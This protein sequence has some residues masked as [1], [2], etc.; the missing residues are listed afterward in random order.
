MSSAQ[1]KQAAAKPVWEGGARV[2]FHYTQPDDAERILAEQIFR[3]AAEPGRAGHGLYVTTVQ[4]RSMPD[5]KLLDLLFAR[6]RPELFV[7]GVV[8]LRD[9]AFSWE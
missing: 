5:E 7:E 2:K 6:G 1:A 4:P 9:D 8:V 3:V